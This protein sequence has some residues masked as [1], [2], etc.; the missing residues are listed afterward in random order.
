MRLKLQ[1]YVWIAILFVFGI[2][3]AVH[4]HFELGIPF[5]PGEKKTAWVV[6]AKIKFEALGKPVKVS[7]NLPDNTRHLIVTETAAATSGYGFHLSGRDAEERGVWSARQRSGADTLY[8]RVNVYRGAGTPSS[9]AEEKPKPPKKPVFGE[10][11]AIAADAILADAFFLSADAE[12]MAV[13]LVRL[14]NAEKPTG[15]VRTLLRN[16]KGDSQRN[17]LLLD[18]LHSAGE[19]ARLLRG[20]D[21]NEAERHHGLVDL[22]EVFNSDT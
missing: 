8:Y 14:L 20:I 10:P 21:L 3:R 9:V 11:E 18:L 7:L 1:L 2:G 16:V 6:E 19:P 13:R 22:I 5:L 15:N 17:Q 4:L 12:S